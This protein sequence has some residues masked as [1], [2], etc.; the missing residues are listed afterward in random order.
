[1][2][3]ENSR[4]SVK[5]CHFLNFKVGKLL[6]KIDQ[7][8]GSTK[9]CWNSFK[10]WKMEVTHENM[11]IFEFLNRQVAR[12]NRLVLRKHGGLLKFFLEIE[13]SKSPVKIDQ[14]FNFKM[15][16]SLVKVDHFHG[17]MEACWNSFWNLK[18]VGHP[19]KKAN[20]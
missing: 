5:I 3:F 12:E 14:F 9:A 19:W 4:S 6:V 11:L 2:E 16:M 1:L 13:K 17:S 8:Q 10:I 15:G 7:F 18:R 20:F